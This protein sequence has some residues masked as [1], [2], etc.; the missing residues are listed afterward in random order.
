MLT[1]EIRAFFEK[2]GV[3]L[4]DEF[5]EQY[6]KNENHMLQSECQLRGILRLCKFWKPFIM[7][8]DFPNLISEQLLTFDRIH[9][10][11]ISSTTNQNAYIGNCARVIGKL[12]LHYVTQCNPHGRTSI[13]RGFGSCRET[14]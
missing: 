9:C 8:D 1:K 6:A 3:I 4:S 5:E 11:V 14:L 2:N 13:V 12:P 10:S 7:K